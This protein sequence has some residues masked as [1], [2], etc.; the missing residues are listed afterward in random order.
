MSGS[1]QVKGKKKISTCLRNLYKTKLV[2]SLLSMNWLTDFF[3][4][5]SASFARALFFHES[6]VGEP[7]SV[8]LENNSDHHGTTTSDDVPKHFKAAMAW[9]WPRNALIHVYTD[10]NAG[11]IP[12][13]A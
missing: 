3:K 13:V 7:N 9:L 5:L 6:P 12:H 8:P 1:Q 10:Y 2:V 4:H 11:Y